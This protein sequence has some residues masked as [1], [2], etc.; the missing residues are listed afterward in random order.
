M[1]RGYALCTPPD[2][3][4]P[5]SRP[6]RTSHHARGVANRLTLAS[7]IPK[8]RLVP[9]QPPILDVRDLVIRF[10]A[11]TLGPL[12]FAIGGG[13]TVALLGANA[14]GKTTLLRAV[15]G[16]L[17]DRSG[18]IA[19]AGREI[20]DAPP[21]WRARIGFA[22]EAP[23]ADPALRVREWFHFLA[24]AY[25][26][27]QRH[28][29]RALVDRLD[30]DTSVR[31]GTLSRGSQVKVAFVAAE[32]YRPDLLVL[33]EP[34]NG[35]DPVVRMAFLSLLRERFSN[36]PDRALLFSS[37]LLEDVEALCDRALLIRDGEL[38]RECSRAEM[39]EARAA[40][41]LTELVADVLRSRG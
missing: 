22:A 9:L 32:A 31:V 19:L 29:E 25:P 34:T 38:V 7:G 14:A 4:D 11:F 10:P 2:L 5:C 23:L 30:I 3:A 6:D 20:R 27:W 26:G 13:E 15:T 39:G 17:H 24:D 28:E 41:R 37:H 12:S 18:T 21:E 16:R 40:G 35:L 33:D 36:A 1:H 8:P